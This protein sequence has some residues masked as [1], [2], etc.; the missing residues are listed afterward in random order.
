M[1]MPRDVYRVLSDQGEHYAILESVID[2]FV[3]APIS[4]AECAREIGDSYGNVKREA[5]RHT[6]DLRSGQ[7]A[8]VQ[9]CIETLKAGK[10]LTDAEAVDVDNFYSFLHATVAAHQYKY[11]EAGK[12]TVNKWIDE[13]GLWIQFPE[14]DDWWEMVGDHAMYPAF[15]NVANVQ[16]SDGVIEREAPATESQNILAGRYVEALAKI[17]GLLGESRAQPA[18]VMR[19]FH[20]QLLTRKQGE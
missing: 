10:P 6:L 12:H 19:R 14:C 17:A 8:H 11:E 13:L 2:Q 7:L 15:Q 4:L 18:D 20:Q 3:T 9:H 16:Q 1:K 5:A